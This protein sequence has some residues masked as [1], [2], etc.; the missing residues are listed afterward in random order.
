MYLESMYCQ[1][2]CHGNNVRVVTPKKVNAGAKVTG[3]NLGSSFRQLCDLRLL[4]N[5]S[6][7]FL[8]CKR[9]IITVPLTKGNCED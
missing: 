4:S 8:I 1:I 6:F 5:F 2:T 3:L 9:G 7:N